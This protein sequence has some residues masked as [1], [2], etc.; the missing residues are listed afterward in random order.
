LKYFHVRFFIYHFEIARKMKLIFTSLFF[1]LLTIKV[2]SQPVLELEPFTTQSIGQ[3][4]GIISAG[5]D[6]LFAVIQSGIIRVINQDGTILQEPFLD[7]RSR[8]QSGGERGLL[9]LAFH[10]DFP[11]NNTFYLNY[12]RPGNATVIS[13]WRMSEDNSNVADDTSEEILM[14]IDQPFTNHNGGDLRFGPDGFLYIGMGDGGSGN[15]PQ[16][17]SQNRQSLLGK[18]LRIDIDT[19]EGYRIPDDNPFAMDD[20]TLDEIWALGL[21]NPWR[22]SFDRENS[23]L[24]IADVG[25]NAI[26]EVN[27]VGAEST[28]GENYGWR[29]YEGTRPNILSGCLSPDNYVFPVFEYNHSQGDRSITG[30][31]VYRG[32]RYPN[33]RGYYIFADFVSSSFFT[34]K[35]TEEGFESERLGLLGLPSP[36]S[37][38]ENSEGEL[39]VASYFAGTIFR[40]IDFC[41]AYTPWL[42]YD[43]ENDEMVIVLESGD[44]TADVTIEWFLDGALI[45]DQTE[46]RLL[47]PENGTYTVKVDHNKG[48]TATSEP[49]FLMIS[50]LESESWPSSLKV[51]P[52]PST[53]VLNF[54]SDLT[55]SV[56]FSLVD[57]TGKVVESFVLAPSAVSQFTLNLSPGVYFLQG[58]LPGGGQV[59]T[60]VVMY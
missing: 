49:Y 11:E 3:V 34:L 47:N 41:Q 32:N 1:T 31:F 35:E 2:F 21:R 7:I 4:V 10:P 36:S 48:C 53:G 60:K 12:T 8:V 54:T 55:G 58:V 52:N 29:C 50:S 13:R 51:W 25:Q 22:F 23:D 44:W 18:L 5:D 57:V 59:Q 27:K 26:E 38:G 33:L 56:S 37:F 20:E 16:N 39:F 19:E 28:G 6:R 9:G 43:E 17:L 42:E 14:V 40:V 45:E 24:W 15:D 30:G 46:N